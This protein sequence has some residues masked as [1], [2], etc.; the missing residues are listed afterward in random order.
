[1]IPKTDFGP[2]RAALTAFDVYSPS[3]LPAVNAP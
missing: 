1:V 2:D 3:T